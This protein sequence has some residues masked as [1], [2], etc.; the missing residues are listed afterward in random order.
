MAYEALNL[1]FR[2]RLFLLITLLF[3]QFNAIAQNLVPNPSFEELDSCI[4]G[5]GQLQKAIGWK[6]ILFTPDCLNRCGTGL[7]YSVPGNVGG[8]Q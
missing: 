7:A 8:F 3:F 2:Q 6:T 4:T 1:L 5:L